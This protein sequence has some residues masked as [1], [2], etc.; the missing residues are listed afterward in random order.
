[1][2]GGMLSKNQIKYIRSLH[3]AKFRRQE[4]LFIAEGPKLALELLNSD[5]KVHSIHCLEEWH[6][7]NNR[8]CGNIPVSI[9]SQK[10]LERISALQTPNEVLL[11]VHTHR[12]SSVDPVPDGDDL[13]LVLDGIRDPGNMG[14]I[15][16]TADWYGVSDIVCSNDCVE[17]YNPKV[18]QATMGSIARVRITY[19][20]LEVFFT[21]K[22]K[23]LPVYGAL[24]DGKS[25][26][27]QQLSA[28]GYLLIG[29][30]S[31]GISSSLTPCITHPLLIPPHSRAGAESL[32][33]SV[34]TAIVLAEFR[35][36]SK[37]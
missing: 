36:R 33:A 15:I 7:A 32:N 12:E 10:E 2:P 11:L 23:A 20:D 6:N 24:L 21:G 19:R 31:H 17:V 28:P 3:L 22:D 25:I 35:R 37:L 1:M 29:S 16:R 8:L 18:V 13:V 30:E 5:F 26:Y 4:K 9:I 27:E 14:T 34:A